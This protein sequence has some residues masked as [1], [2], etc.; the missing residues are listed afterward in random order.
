M[1]AEART[2]T[3]K[4]PLKAPTSAPNSTHSGS[5]MGQGKGITPL[6]SRYD[7]TAIT[8]PEDRSSERQRMTS[9]CP[10]AAKPS[11]AAWRRMSSSKKGESRLGLRAAALASSTRVPR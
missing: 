8:P 2:R 5:A 6:V 4:K 1:T 9:D 11:G 7:T 10:M 3:I